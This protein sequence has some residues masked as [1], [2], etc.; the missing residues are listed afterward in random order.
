M[1]AQVNTQ[2]SPVTRAS[3]VNTAAPPPPST[4]MSTGQKAAVAGAAVVGGLTLTTLIISAATGWG[5]G[6]VLD[7]AWDKI[8]GHKPR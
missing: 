2:L 7:K 8:S 4:G 6:R 3:G 1:P 5:I